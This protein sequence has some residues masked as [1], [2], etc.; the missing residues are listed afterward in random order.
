MMSEF[1]EKMKQAL[2]RMGIHLEGD[3]ILLSRPVRMMGEL[4]YEPS[5]SFLTEIAENLATNQDN[6]ST[7]E[8]DIASNSADIATNTA[9]IDTLQGWWD[10]KL[11]SAEEMYPVSGSPNHTD[12]N[13]RPAWGLDKDTDEEIS[14][15]F[16]LEPDWDDSESVEIELL[17]GQKTTES[18][19]NVRIG[20]GLIQTD[21][22]DTTSV[23]ATW[24]YEIVSAPGTQYKVKKHTFDGLGTYTK[25]DNISWF[26]LRIV[27]DANNAGDTFDNDIHIIAAAVKYKRTRT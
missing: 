4:F 16:G 25:T 17:I 21:D 12:L 27:R 20:L 9:D 5:G 13:R 22:G 19:G 11:I 10:Y 26:A 18:S 24:D 8:T 14:C 15:V 7:N 2:S 3:S 23:A 6:I 1:R